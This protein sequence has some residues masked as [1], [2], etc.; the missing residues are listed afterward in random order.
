MGLK[1]DII[2]N[3]LLMPTANFAQCRAEQKDNEDWDERNEQM[4]YDMAFGSLN[5]QRE[6]CSAEF[7]K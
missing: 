4:D 3:Q 6:C 5:R 7:R 1:V 2:E